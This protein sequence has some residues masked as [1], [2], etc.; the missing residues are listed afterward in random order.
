VQA[1]K[2][3]HA[4][5][6]AVGIGR[7][8]GDGDRDRATVV[9]NLDASA[10]RKNGSAKVKSDGSTRLIFQMQAGCWYSCDANVCG[11]KRQMMTVAKERDKMVG[12]IRR[13][14]NK[15]RGGPE[16]RMGK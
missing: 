14:E 11:V 7:D 9:R 3:G 1:Q 10:A 8:E 13:D 2:V 15:R 4:I 6:K 5:A 12:P 16:T